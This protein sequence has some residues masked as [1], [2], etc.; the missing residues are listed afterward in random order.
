MLIVNNNIFLQR[1]LG[2]T[3]ITLSKKIS[4]NFQNVNDNVLKRNSKKPLF[5][6]I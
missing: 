1:Y 6:D 5:K 2:K 3:K 4:V